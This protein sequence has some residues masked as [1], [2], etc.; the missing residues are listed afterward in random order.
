M[1]ETA[2]NT[3]QEAASSIGA[4]VQVAPGVIVVGADST[5]LAKVKELLFDADAIQKYILIVEDDEAKYEITQIFK[6]LP[7][8]E[9]LEYDRLR[10]VLLETE[11]EKS[12]I[13]TDSSEADNY[14]FKELCIDVEGFEG[15]KPANWHDLIEYAEKK[16]GI[17]KLLGVK[18]VTSDK[19]KVVKKRQWGQ[20]I[21]SNMVTLKSRFNGEILTTKAFFKDQ[22][23]ADIAEY[24]LIKNRISLVDKDLDDSA[25]K[26]PA[27][28]RQKAKLFDRLKPQVEG[29]ARRVPVHHKAA[30]I[31][32]FFEPKISNAEKK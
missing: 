11:G 22:T 31:T 15:E 23:P 32:G 16:F 7:D 18:I 13:N 2:Q 8:D 5:G 9:I 3:N 4:A 25:I 28:M 14:L 10:E 17:G 29:Y 20:R 24:S 1:L 30:F 21:Q 27:S 6:G 19:E 26:I 12:S